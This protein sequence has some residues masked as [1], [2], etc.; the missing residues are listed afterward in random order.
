MQ[1]GMSAKGQKR[2]IPSRSIVITSCQEAGCYIVSFSTFGDD[3]NFLSRY[4]RYLKD[5]P[6]QYWFKRAAGGGFLQHGK[7]G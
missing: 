6:E 2:I 1:L 3:M 5:N 7:D 4:I